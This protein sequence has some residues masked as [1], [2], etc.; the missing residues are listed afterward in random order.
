[1]DFLEPSQNWNSYS[2]I[3]HDATFMRMRDDYIKNG[4]LK[5][6]YNLQI[7]TENQFT[8]PYEKF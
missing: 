2:E 1:M 7:T 5:L 8:F 6:S 3:D 4:Q